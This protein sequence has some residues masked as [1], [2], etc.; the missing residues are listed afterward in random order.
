MSFGEAT[1]TRRPNGAAS[2]PCGSG[3]RFSACCGPLLDG[4][5]AGTAEQLMRSRYTAFALR[6]EPYLMRTWHPETR[7]RSVDLDPATR[8][9]GLTIERARG[10]TDDNAGVVEFRARWRA[11]DTAGELHEVSR[12]ER[13]RARWVYVDGVTDEKPL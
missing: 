7:P 4:V 5:A 2:C 13:R 12:F 3:A 11:G 8:W 1:G 10:G 6:D 9:V